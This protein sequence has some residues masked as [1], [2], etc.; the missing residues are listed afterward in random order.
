MS[1][2][3]SYIIGISGGTGAGKT[4]LSKNI[5]KTLGE[6]NV[7]IIDMDSYYKDSPV[8]HPTKGGRINFDHPN[9]VDSRLLEKH[10]RILKDGKPVEKHVYDFKNHLRTQQTVTV[11]PK[12]LIIVEGIL[13]FAIKKISHYFDLKIYVQEDADIRL[14]RRILRDTSERGRSIEAIAEQYIRSVKPMHKKFVEPYS[15]QAD[16][17]YR[18]KKDLRKILNVLKKL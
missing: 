12:P 3:L 15:L 6:K 11:L 8:E 18:G 4:I 7:S 16:I 1:Y 17:I 5:A 2:K 13:C 10:I 9:A 14:L